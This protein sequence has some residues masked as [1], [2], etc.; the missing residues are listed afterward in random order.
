LHPLPPLSFAIVIL[1]SLFKFSLFQFVRGGG[2]PSPVVKKGEK[3]MK[4]N[5]VKRKKV[6]MSRGNEKIR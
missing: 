4:W 3:E 2:E 5:N 1:I 6:E